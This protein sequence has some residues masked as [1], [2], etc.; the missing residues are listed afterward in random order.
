MTPRSLRVAVVQT[1]QDLRSAGPTTIVAASVLGVGIAGAVVLLSTLSVGFSPMPPVPAVGDVARVVVADDE[2]AAGRRLLPPQT[3]ERWQPSE[4][5]FVAGIREDQRTLEDAIGSRRVRVQA[6]SEDFH[7]LVTVAP[8]LGIPL[9]PDLRSTS[10]D[11]IL[12][13]APLARERGL[14]LGDMLRLDGH[15]HTVAG[16]MP[17]GFWF[18]ALPGADVWMPM[19]TDRADAEHVQVFVRR[20]RSADS[21]LAVSD[22]LDR[23]LADTDGRRIKLMS[24]DED[25]LRRTVV[26]SALLALPAAALI[27]LACF[28]ASTLLLVSAFERRAGYVT[29]LALGASPRDLLGAIALHAAIVALL[30]SALAFGV[31]ALGLATVGALLSQVNPMLAAQLT[32]SWTAIGVGAACG[33]LALAGSVIPA[34]SAVVSS[35]T[36]GQLAASPSYQR[37][38]RWTP[39]LIAVQVALSGVAIATGAM[40]ESVL[41]RAVSGAQFE[42]DRVALI[43]VRPQSA[44]SSTALFERV[45]SRMNLEAVTWASEVPRLGQT[46]VRGV[47]VTLEQPPDGEASGSVRARPV[48]VD[49]SYFAALRLPVLQ[50][51]PPA[52]A[53]EAALS[54][55]LALALGMDR[56]IGR[57]IKVTVNAEPEARTVTAVV[58]D[59]VDDAGLTRPPHTL[60]SALVSE[61]QAGYLLA[62]AFSWTPALERELSDAV[63]EDRAVDATVVRLRAAFDAP[64]RGGRVITL[65]LRAGG[66]LALALALVGT[67]GLASRILSQRRREVAIRLAI[68]ASYPSVLTSTFGDLMKVVLAGFGA[69]V[70]VTLIASV[71]VWPAMVSSS[72]GGPVAWGRVFVPLIVSALAAFWVPAR[73]LMRTQPGEILREG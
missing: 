49:R 60:Y 72:L 48:S 50:G 36:T 28:N 59:D 54:R 15:A 67:Y 30:A 16:V 68:G 34:A 20:S 29:R 53:T 71:F 35:S 69:G 61:P 26:G 43:A 8:A 57:Q 58:A 55:S 56:A 12:V 47:T 14:A 7:R 63:G 17:E 3:L 37:V 13:S 44:E 23:Q 41:D 46:G 38:D 32:Y 27:L 11:T 70:V 40:A 33:A 66:G 65:L 4:R 25:H 31:V 1:A 6:V 24:L 64:L 19:S 45:R 5:F 62:S 73:R 18:P 42:T 22:E 21:W 9:A 10:S 52:D 51:R 2:N 39:S